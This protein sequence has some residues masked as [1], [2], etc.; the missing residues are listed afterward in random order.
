MQQ[1][2]E[3]VKQ[4]H[5]SGDYQPL[6]DLIPYA[7]V[8]G[9]KCECYGEE[10]IFR[11]PSN[12]D[13]IGNPTIPAIH[14][15][16]IASFME[17]TALFQLTLQLPQPGLAKIIDFSVDYMR[18]GLDRDTFAI[19][20]ISRQGRRVGNC[21]VVAWQERKSKPIAQARAHFLLDTRVTAEIED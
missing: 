21:S 16:V 14:G 2:L 11:L 19:C 4:A 6:V 18:S 15:G 5:A 17:L 12:P 1:L 20:Q 10:I 7:Q 9:V 3:L 8:L 13:N